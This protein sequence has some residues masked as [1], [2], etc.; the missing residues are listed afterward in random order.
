MRQVGPIVLQIGSR[1]VYLNVKFLYGS[2]QVGES[3]DHTFARNNLS[4]ASFSSQDQRLYIFV[5]KSTFFM[6]VNFANFE[7]LAFNDNTFISCFKSRSFFWPLITSF[8]KLSLIL[9]D[10]KYAVF[11]VVYIPQEKIVE[12][13]LPTHSLPNVKSS[14]NSF[15]WTADLSFCHPEEFTSLSLTHH[16]NGSLTDTFAFFAVRTR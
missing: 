14:I 10:E 5:P 6:L 9:Y 11:W 4:G 3:E 15:L 7:K 13:L 12:Q 16:Q 8:L 1:L 2:H